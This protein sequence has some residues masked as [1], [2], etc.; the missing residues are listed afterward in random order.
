MK[1]APTNE[2]P[3]AHIDIGEVEEV[4]QEEE[5]S[6]ETSVVLPINPLKKLCRS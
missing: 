2:N 3:H 1:H 5:V 4:G 6:V